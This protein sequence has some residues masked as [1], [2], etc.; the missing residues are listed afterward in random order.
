MGPRSTVLLVVDDPAFLERAGSA[1]GEAGYAVR[2]VRRAGEARAALAGGDCVAALVGLVL[3]DEDGLALASE[4]RATSPSLVLV[5]V[6][7]GWENLAPAWS[8]DAVDDVVL[9]TASGGELAWRVAAR[10][11]E[12]RRAGS[13]RQRERF[14]RA[15]VRLADHL[16]PYSD[17]P[18]LAHALAPALL[19]LPGVEAARVE[20]EAD[21]VGELPQVVLEAGRVAAFAASPANVAEIDLRTVGGRLLLAH[22]ADQAFD[23]D[24][25]D[26]LGA[27]VGAALSSARQ[28]GAL[29][30]RQLRLE[31][32][33]V[34]RHRKLSRVSGRLERLSEARDS[35][36][37]LLSHDLR[38]PLAIILGQ[39][40]LMEEGLVPAGQ[41]GRVAATVR[42][43][44]DRMVQMVEELLDRYRRDDAVRTVPDS[45]DAARI[46]V[47]MVENLRPLALA[48]RQSLVLECVP[49]APIEADVAAIREVLAN[50][51]ENAVRYSP[52]GSTVRVTVVC[53]DGRV[54][55]AIHDQG[56]GFGSRELAGGSGASI[57]LRASARIL[58]D[59]GGALRTQNS[60][61]GGGIA[62]VVLPLAVPQAVAAAVEL[63]AAPGPLGD[64]LAGTL[65]RHWEVRA[66]PALGGALERMRRQP[67]AVVVV[68]RSV[69]PEAVAFVRRL[70]SDAELAAVPVIAV[71]D[72]AGELYDAGALAVLRLP[73]DAPLLVGHVR[74]ALRLVGEAP[75]P[76]EPA[77]DV[78][79]GLPTARA[80]STRLDQALAAARQAG[81][82]VPV[83]IVRVDEL[84]K[85]N[86][87]QGWL[88]GDQMLIWVA[89]RLR[90]RLRPG[91]TVAR[92]DAESFALALP[93]RT[94]AEAEASAT[95][96]REAFARARP[97]LGLARVDVRVS[98]QALDLTTLALGGDSLIGA[99]R[100]GRES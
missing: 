78:L 2:P 54:V 68:D 43:Q 86:R 61:A 35:F 72:D 88:V 62:T 19:G 67:P 24:V 65:V 93:G 90:E 21:A 31:R 69:D 97:R 84:R 29:K 14:L 3:P 58:A 81:A 99:V 13:S 36:L 45:G 32:G 12:R 46:V 23:S 44:G 26:A 17:L 76:G 38:S 60:P 77:P 95:E 98:A 100:G 16:S 41:V 53:E 50:L 27:L 34:E 94:L 83:V 85:V 55:C 52:E 48:R 64:Q 51:L 57:G 20:L 10:D 33:Y 91:E 4:L 15:V 25:R 87:Q 40:Q 11:L 8:L 22:A 9:L 73:L 6:A 56:A 63:F 5:A 47:D 96:V 89:A 18:S 1:L 59:A 66:S 7:D 80:L 42:R 82:P 39:V 49:N 79:T 74:R 30:D 75:T 92:V 70:K 71:G 37:A 28:F